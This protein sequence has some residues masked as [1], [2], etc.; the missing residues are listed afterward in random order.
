[1]G[2]FPPCS[3]PI[4]HPVLKIII[5]KKNCIEFE[6]KY[7][8]GNNYQKNSVVGNDREPNSVCYKNL[9]LSALDGDHD[10]NRN[11]ALMAGSRAKRQVDM[12]K[13]TVD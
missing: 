1:M 3:Q 8:S 7:K 6:R 13:L 4:L 11:Y 10:G 9:L 2:D 12:E 5:I